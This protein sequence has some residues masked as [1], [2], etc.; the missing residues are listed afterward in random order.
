MLRTAS[1]AALLAAL[2]AAPAAAAQVPLPPLGGGGQQPPPEQ[3]PQPAPGPDARKQ[4]PSYARLSDERRLSRWAHAVER[5]KVRKKPS[6]ASRS[7]TRL[8][9][10]TED[11]L[12]EVY[13]ALRRYDAADGRR[14]IQV[15]LPMRPNGRTGWVPREALGRLHVVRTFLLVDRR[16]LRATLFRSG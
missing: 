9:Y 1:G 5:V 11:G 14:W 16:R 4:Q 12:P 10:D 7:I 3:Q 2:A 15:R 8:R 13:L 6:S